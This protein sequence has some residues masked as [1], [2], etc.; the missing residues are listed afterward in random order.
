MVCL[1]EPSIQSAEAFKTKCISLQ[2]KVKKI[3]HSKQSVED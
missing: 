1:R 2:N 3:E